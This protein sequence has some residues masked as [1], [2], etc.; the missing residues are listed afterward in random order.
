MEGIQNPTVSVVIPTYNR[1][2]IVGR[3][4]KSVL[5][6]TYQDWEIVVV[7]DGS[8]DDTRAAVEAFHEPRIRFIAHERN[9]GQCAAWNT[10]INAARGKYVAFLDSDDEWL[11]EKLAKSVEAFGKHDE[12]VGLVYSGKMLLEEN[13]TVLG[14]RT[15]TLQGNVHD[16]LLAWDFIGSCTRVVV[17][18]DVLRQVGGFDLSLP[19][20]DDWD[21]WIRVSKVSEVAAIEECLVKRYLG[22]DQLSGSLKRIYEGKVRVIEKHRAEMPPDVLAKHLAG[23]AIVLFNYDLAGGWI[24]AR[25]A[26]RLRPLQPALLVALA[27]SFLG[28][29][30]YTRLFRSFTRRFHALYIGRARI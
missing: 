20:C 8:K 24:K 5:G 21:L 3:A 30:T 7:D 17:R 27:A 22:P 14:V 18:R 25:E 13:G 9:Q 11:P 15:P 2:H 1:A 29:G 16:A 28:T 4:V 6:Q 19:S 23:L 26:L 10:G 12:R